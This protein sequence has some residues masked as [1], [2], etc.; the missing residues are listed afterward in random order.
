MRKEQPPLI[1]IAEASEAQ[2]KEQREIDERLQLIREQE[3]QR[4]LERR[5]EK[6]DQN[7]RYGH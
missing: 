4:D 1:K 2:E 7:P 3:R 5:L 6:D